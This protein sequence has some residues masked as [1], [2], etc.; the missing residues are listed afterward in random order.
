MTPQQIACIVWTPVFAIFSMKFFI[1]IL[2]VTW[3]L[4][5]CKEIKGKSNTNKSK[6]KVIETN[7]NEEELKV[8]ASKK[9][10]TEKNDIENELKKSELKKKVSE[11]K[12]NKELEEQKKIIKKAS[13]KIKDI[14]RVLFLIAS[15]ISVG[16]CIAILYADEGMQNKEIKK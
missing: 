15:L 2:Q 9:Q 12:E 13:N 11:K 4:C 6:K 10:V 1:Q 7:R 14:C 5:L 3:G 16:E 8:N